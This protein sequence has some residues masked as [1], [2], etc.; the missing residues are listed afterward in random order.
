MQRKAGTDWKAQ[1]QNWM[2][3]NIGE[4]SLLMSNPPSFY[5]TGPAHR[6]FVDGRTNLV[7]TAQQL[8]LELGFTDKIRHWLHCEP[9]KPIFLAKPL[10]KPY[11]GY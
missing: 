7:R 4:A 3:H 5:V 10:G 1:A 8:W 9:E 2:I 6:L 11:H